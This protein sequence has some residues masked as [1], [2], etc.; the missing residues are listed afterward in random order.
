MKLAR[1][2]VIDFL[3]LIVFEHP[4]INVQIDY[5]IL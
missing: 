4:I 2:R 1:I 5:K 3:R